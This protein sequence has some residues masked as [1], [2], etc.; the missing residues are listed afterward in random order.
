MREVGERDE[1]R[2]NKN[3]LILR[4]AICNSLSPISSHFKGGFFL[5][6]ADA[7]VVYEAGSKKH[8]EHERV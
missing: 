3:L 5:F 2:E 1:R 7:G 4:F 8:T 6:L